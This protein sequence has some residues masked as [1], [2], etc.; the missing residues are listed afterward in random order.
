M[1]VLMSLDMT[2]MDITDMALIVL[3]TTDMALM[4][5]DL[6]ELAI[7]ILLASM[8]RKAL[9]QCAWTAEVKLTFTLCLLLPR[10][11]SSIPCHLLNNG[12]KTF[13]Q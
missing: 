12:R 10:L 6:T 5:R 4:W 13:Y 2:T 7:Q 3:A 11:T 8:E 9:T 1:M